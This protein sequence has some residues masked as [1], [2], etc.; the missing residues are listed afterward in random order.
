M[1]PRIRTIAAAQGERMSQA[2]PEQT[3]QGYAAPSVRQFSVFL[4]NRPGRLLDVV[5]LFEE[6][7]SVA[8]CGFSVVEASDYAVVRLITN[9]A[10]ATR[11]LLR[12]H[13]LTYS[14]VDL[15]VVEL[16]EGHSLG[17]LCLYLLG[18]ELNIRFAYPLMLRPNGTPTIAIAVDDHVLAGQI[19][20]RKTF[21]MLGECDL[22]G[23]HED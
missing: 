4:E 20:R 13:R 16:T 23:S 18:A 7:P 22:P 17:S 2:V 6:A 8:L 14:E 3:M 10:E 9:N 5:Q 15:L 12:G 19:L 11:Q 1:P 21:H